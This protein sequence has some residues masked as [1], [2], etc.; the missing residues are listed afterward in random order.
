VAKA[1][2]QSY[3]VTRKQKQKL[4]P[5][6]D[7]YDIMKF[8]QDKPTFSNDSSPPGGDG[9]DIGPLANQLAKTSNNEQ[10]YWYQNQPGNNT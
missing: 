2:P 8:H 5:L 1:P 6:S 7:I 4:T 9:N 10:A 3:Q